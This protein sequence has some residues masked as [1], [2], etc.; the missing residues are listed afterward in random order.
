MVAFA[1]PLVRI[2]LPPSRAA[3]N[4]NRATD[5][6]DKTHCWFGFLCALQDK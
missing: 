1:G 5:S 3:R 2:R 6:E 4:E